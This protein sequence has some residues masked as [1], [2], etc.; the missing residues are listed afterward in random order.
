MS[1]ITYVLTYV[2][3]K[4]MIV[5]TRPPKVVSVLSV[6]YNGFGIINTYLR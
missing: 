4:V 2:W 5:L 1:T 3:I 6:Q